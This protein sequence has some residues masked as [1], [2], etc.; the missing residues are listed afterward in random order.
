MASSQQQQP[1]PRGAGTPS[2]KASKVRSLLASYYDADEREGPASQPAAQSAGGGT[3]SSSPVPGTPPTP[4]NASYFDADAYLRRMLRELRLGDLTARHREMLG[5]VR[6]AVAAAAPPLR[7]LPAPA[8]SSPPQVGTL[9]SDMQ[10]LVYEN[11]NKFVTATDTIKLMSASMEGMDKNMGSLRTLIGGWVGLGPGL[12]QAGAG[13]AAASRPCMHHH[14]HP[15]TQT[16][17]WS[18]AMP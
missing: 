5:E 11:Y 14:H 3:S 2:D 7:V 17:P 1:S 4:L 9:D 16:R 18:T 12:A 13:A 10:Q 15:A 8:A 6:A